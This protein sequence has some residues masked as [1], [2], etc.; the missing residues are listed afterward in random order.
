[1]I[2]EVGELMRTL[3]FNRPRRYSMAWSRSDL[4][5]SPC[6]HAIVVCFLLLTFVITPVFAQDEDLD[7]PVEA[8]NSL[9]PIDI[10][11]APVMIDGDSYFL[12]R[13][14]LSYSAEERAA[15]I[16]ESILK[17]AKSGGSLDPSMRQE[18]TENGIEIYAEGELITGVTMP[19]AALEGFNIEITANL[20]SD[21]IA[22]AIRNYRKIR[23][24]SG[25]QQGAIN[26]L[27]WTLAFAVLV[28]GLLL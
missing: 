17:A 4:L 27:G 18:S 11:V 14:A 3:G 24:T 13:G 22:K 25:R 21:E 19:D 9:V 15:R 8:A 28:G 5:F 2:D 16:E 10:P 23:T 12:V 7:T 26:T 20:I 6:T 1:M